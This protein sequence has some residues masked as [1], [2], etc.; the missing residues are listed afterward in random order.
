[1]ME[2]PILTALYPA[3]AADLKVL[4]ETFFKVALVPT[5]ISVNVI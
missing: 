2:Q 1:M 3:H 4:L 5:I